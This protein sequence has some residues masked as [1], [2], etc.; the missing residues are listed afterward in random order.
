MKQRRTFILSRLAMLA[1]IPLVV[2]FVNYTTDPASLYGG[3]YEE[4]IASVLLAGDTIQFVYDYDEGRVQKHYVEGLPARREVA[5]MGSSRARQIH[6]G[7]TGDRSFV[8]NAVSGANLEHY[9]AIYGLYRRRG[10]LPG[11]LVLGLDPWIFNETVADCPASIRSSYYQ[12]LALLGPEVY[13]NVL[14]EYKASIR[15]YVELFSPSYFQESI[16]ARLD[17]SAARRPAGALR[18]APAASQEAGAIRSDLSRILSDAQ[19]RRS[20]TEVRQMVR[21]RIAESGAFMLQ[22]YHAL[23]PQRVSLFEGFL[24]LVQEEGVQVVLLLPP[25]HPAYYDYLTTLKSNV[26]TVTVRD[27]EAYLK[28]LAQAKGLRLVGSYDPL[29]LGLTAS[30]FIDGLHPRTETLAKLFRDAGKR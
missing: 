15:I 7:M 16:R 14:R 26:S 8:N 6:R 21:N 25:F 11:T 20:P 29:A 5:V 12:I 10:L 4:R 17:G 18:V 30:D 22:G 9:L 28:V 2:A 24:A 3:S 1:P 19:R 23:D 13:H 27:V